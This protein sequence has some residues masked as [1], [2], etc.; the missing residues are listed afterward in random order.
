VQQEPAALLP[1]LGDVGSMRFAH[2]VRRCGECGSYD[3][4]AGRCTHCDWVDETYEPPQILPL[5]DEEKT[6]RMA[7]PCIP[8]SDLSTFVRPRDVS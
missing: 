6:R 1:G 7:E 3:V 4:R 5:S 8:S 2:N